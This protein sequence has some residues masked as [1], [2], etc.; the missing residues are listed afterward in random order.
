M[1]AGVAFAP[2]DAAGVVWQLGAGVTRWKEGDEVVVTPSVPCGVCA[3]CTG[4]GRGG[5]DRPTVWASALAELAIARDEQ[6]LRKPRKL[7]WEAAGSYATAYFGAYRALVDRAKVRPGEAVLVWDGVRPLGAFA[8]QLARLLG[9]SVGTLEH[10]ARKGRSERLAREVEAL[11]AGR[12]PDVVLVGATEESLAFGLTASARKARLLIVS[13][14][15]PSALDATIVR[16]DEKTILGVSLPPPEE[17]QRANELVH[18]EKIVVPAPTV[19]AFEDFALALR[20]DARGEH[21]SGAALL[22][23]APRPGLTTWAEALAAMG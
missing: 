16:R 20:A 11:F 19:H 9:A 3:A 1:A 10:G 2:G 4:F 15:G 5:C 7:S 22:V 13:G 12:A 6:L 18:Q 21:P 17:C 8:L 23:A 14:E